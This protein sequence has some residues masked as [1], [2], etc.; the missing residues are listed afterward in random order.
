MDNI[1]L[2]K[3]K[4]GHD[5][6]HIYVVLKEEGEFFILANGTTKPIEA[7]KRKKK[8]HV[9]RICHLPDELVDE[10]SKLSELDNSTI[11]NIVEL[12]GRRN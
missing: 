5:K 2:A 9:Q 1:I 10:I 3:S 8:M 7:P 12:Y 4:A 11:S 6:N